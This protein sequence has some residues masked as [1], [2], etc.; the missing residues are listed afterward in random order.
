MSEIID[1]VTTQ[2]HETNLTVQLLHIHEGAFTTI[3]ITDQADKESVMVYDDE[4][5]NLIEA[6]TKLKGELR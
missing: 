2:G 3:V 6:L 1:I 4:I 5:D